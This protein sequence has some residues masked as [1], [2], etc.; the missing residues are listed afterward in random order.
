MH[1]HMH[2]A[3]EESEIAHLFN[4]Y[5]QGMLA[6]VQMQVSS[7]EDADTIQVWVAN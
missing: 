5:S 7:Q 1:I 2:K 3:Q 6:Y 4:T